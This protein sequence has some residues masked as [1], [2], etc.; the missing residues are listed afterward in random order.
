[1]NVLAIIGSPHGMKGNTGRL[2]EEV[3]AGVRENGGDVDLVSLTRLKVLPCIACDACHKVGTCAVDDDFEMIREKLLTCDAVILASPNY[4]F[5]V[6]AQMKALFDR[7][8]G[9]IHLMALEGT[10]GIAVETSGGGEDEDVLKYMERFIAVLGARVVGSI[11]SPV[12]GVRMFPN[13]EALFARARELGTDLCRSVQ[14][15]RSFPEQDAFHDAF[16][17]RMRRLMLYKK[18]EWPYE[19]DV[20]RALGKF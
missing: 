18:D 9:L 19:F 1:M 7:C 16:K 4:I 13:E 2:L 20:W 10:Y 14:E 8:G 15:K 12:A 3:L 6:T 11:G 17:E 5:G